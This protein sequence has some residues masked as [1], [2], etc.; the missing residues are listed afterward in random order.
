MVLPHF[1]TMVIM[2]AVIFVKDDLREPLAR[3]LMAG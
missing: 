1:L 2:T 3:R